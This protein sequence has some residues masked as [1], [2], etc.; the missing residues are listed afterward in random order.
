MVAYS[1][2]KIAA[3]F[4]AYD[5]HRYAYSYAL[6]A[7]Y[8]FLNNTINASSV[9]IERTRDGVQELSMWEPYTWEYT[10]AFAVFLVLPI[11]FYWFKRFPPT[12]SHIPK[13]IIL[14]ILA[15]IVFSI[16]HIL[17]MVLMREAIYSLAGGNYNFGAILSEF[18]YEYRKDAWGYAFW[19]VT[20]NVV[21]MLYRR[22]RGDA[23]L[24]Q[25]ESSETSIQTTPLSPEFLLVKKLDKEFLVKVQDIEFIES[26]GNYV[27]LYKEGRIYPLR[28]TLAKTV[29]RLTQAGFSRTHRSYAVNHSAI[30]SIEYVSS[31]D[32]TLTL[33]SGKTLPLSRRYKESF[34]Q[35]FELTNQSPAM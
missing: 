18:W 11:M 21:S 8:L 9:W 34:K 19:L 10:S 12:F 23:N 5:K 7:V 14:H 27:N 2:E 25:D 16:V 13:Q 4:Q 20:Y 29:E 3:F 6:I 31:G 35:V 26:S 24:I 17:L 30:E 32:G 1:D 15:S 33:K 22:L 28:G